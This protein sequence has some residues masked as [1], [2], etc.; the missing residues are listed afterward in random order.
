[1]IFLLGI[2][3]SWP[4]AF[5]CVSCDGG[6]EEKEKHIEWVALEWVAPDLKFSQWKRE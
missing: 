1:M 6:W 2:Y 4:L 5:A 3:I